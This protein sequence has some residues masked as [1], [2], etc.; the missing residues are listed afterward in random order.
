MW[1]YKAVGASM[2]AIG[3]MTFGGADQLDVFHIPEPEPGPGEVRVRVH[4]ATVNPTD[5]MLRG[6]VLAG[7]FKDQPG[8]YVP[9]MDAAGVVDRLGSGTENRFAL[10]DRVVAFVMPTWPRG[11]AYAEKIVVPVESVVPAPAGADFAA[12]S[13]LLMNAAT[14]RL[15]LDALQLAPGQTLAVTG[16]PGAVGGYI[17]QL[18][19]AEGLHVIA[20]ASADDEALVLSL[21]ADRVV[22]RGEGFVEEVRALIPA[23]VDGLFDGAALNHLVL[24][25]IADNGG[26]AVIRGWAGPAPRGIIIH[27]IL[28]Y[29]AATD[30]KLLDNLRQHVEDGILTLRVADVLPPEQAGDAHR[31]VEAGGLRGRLVLDFSA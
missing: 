26:L 25:A 13:T 22:S 21:G 16:A 14:A 10:G 4:A 6:G 18:A 29:D 3:V 23:G 20:D 28:V 27:K 24:P 30:T 8:P 7:S 1:R 15:S 11:G 9:G 5:V 31:R 2:R 17:I 12:A 19:K